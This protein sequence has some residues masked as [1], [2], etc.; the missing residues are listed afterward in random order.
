[1][2]EAVELRLQDLAR[3]FDGAIPVVL[4]TVSAAGVPNVTYLSKAH[5]V[6]HERIA[7]SNQFLSKSARNL[8]EVPRGSLLIIEPTA[9][10]EYRLDIAYERTERR[11]RVFDELKSEIDAIAAHTGMQEVFRLRAADIYRVTRI[12]QVPANERADGSA[13][14]DPWT[15]RPPRA[16]ADVAGLGE[17]CARIARCTDLDVLVKVTLDGLAELLSYEQSMLLLLDE[18][19]RRLFTLASHG[20]E[21]EGVGSEV[22]VGEGVIGLAAE[23]AA[24]V[25]VGNAHQIAKYARSVR[26]SFEASG[27]IE[28]GREIELPGLPFADSR[29]AVPALALGQLV[30][31]LAVE[32]VA[33]A[34][35]VAADEAALTVIASLVGT[36]IE[37]IRAEERAASAGAPAKTSPSASPMAGAAGAAPTTHVRFFAIDGSTFLDGDYVIKGVAGRLLWSLLRQY[38][39]EGRTE[40]TNREVRLD[41]TLALPDFRDNFESR[42]ILLKR[43]LDE[44]EAT[45]RVEKTGRGRF[46]LAVTGNVR[47]DELPTSS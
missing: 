26:R 31:V 9:H 32:A 8:A 38:E 25:R 19:G 22:A 24:P 27:A 37:S 39:R 30:G 35:F 5:V 23:R 46:R 21:H 18:G 47:L 14:T 33:S 11:G 44:R 28:P 42:L 7:L 12:R 13:G 43:R 17:L 6:D 34:E 16:T 20:Y 40:F 45:I 29:V 41:P 15:T 4:V 3:C 2:T 36:A 10:D 1:M